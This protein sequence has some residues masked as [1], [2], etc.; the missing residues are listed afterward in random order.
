MKK[1]EVKVGRLYYA[2]VNNRHTVV[3]VDSIR[4]NDIGGTYYGVTNLTTGRTTVF[5][6]AAALHHEVKQEVCPQ[7]KTHV[8]V[9]HDFPFGMHEE[10]Y[11]RSNAAKL[12]KSM[13]KV[14]PSIGNV[15]DN[16]ADEDTTPPSQAVPLVFA[17]KDADIGEGEHSADSI[18]SKFV[19]VVDTAGQTTV[20]APTSLAAKIAAQSAKPRVPAMVAGYT[21]TDEQR[22]ILE[23]V[24]DILNS[25]GPKVLVVN[26]GAGSGKTS[27]LKML[28]DV[29]YG[30]IQYTAYNRPLVDESRS[31]F[32]KAKC[33][34]GH[35]L[36]FAPV[37]KDYKHRL[38]GE[39]IRS[40]DVARMLG[41]EPYIIE[42]PNLSIV[43]DSPEWVEA[44]QNAGYGEGLSR[45]VVPPTDWVPK[46]LK[47]VEAWLLAGHVS[48]ALKRFS[49]T[50]DQE[51]GM[52]HFAYIDGIDQVDPE[53]G[54]RS[55]KN[56]DRVVEYLLPF[57]KKFWA[58]VCDVN[59]VL[60]YQH[61]FYVKQWQ[62]SST[63]I[64]PADHILLDE[65]FPVG[66]MVETDRGPIPIETISQNP[67]QWCVLSSLNGGRTTRYTKVTSAY[68]TPRNG[69]LVRIEHDRGE[70]VCTANHPIW[71]GGRGW[72]AAGLVERGDTL[73][74]LRKANEE[75]TG[76]LLSVLCK[77]ATLSEGV[78]RRGSSQAVQDQQENEGSAYRDTQS[79]G[80]SRC[81]REGVGQNE[82]T[83]GRTAGASGRQWAGTDASRIAVVQGT[84]ASPSELAVEPR[85]C[86]LQWTTKERV[87]NLLQDRHSISDETHCGR[88]GRRL[89]QEPEGQRERC[90]EDDRIRVSRVVSVEVYQPGDREQPGTSSCGDYRSVY[91][92]SVEAGNYYADGV[93]A[94]NCQDTAPVFADVIRRQ[95]ATIIL[96]GDENQKIYEWR[97]ACN[98]T[99]LFPDAPILYLSQSF[100]FGQAVADI[101]NSVLTHLTEPT[102]LK[103]RG[104]T[105]IP[106]RVL[107]DLPTDEFGNSATDDRESEHVGNVCY[108]YRT[109]AGA[110]G[111][112][113]TEFARGRRGCLVGKV[114]EV[115]RWVEAARDLQAAIPKRTSHPELAVFESWKEVQKYVEEDP[116]GGDLKLMVKLVDEFTCKSILQALNNMPEEKDADFVCSTSHKSKGRE[117]DTVVLGADFPAA[118]K[119]Q[120]SDVRLLY[121]AA[122]R[123]KLVLDLT[124]CTP[125]HSYRDKDGNEYPAIEINYTTDMPSVNELV[126]YRLVKDAPHIAA[127]TVSPKIAS[128][129]SQSANGLSPQLAPVNAAQ[130]NVATANG[131]EQSRPP[132]TGFSWTNFGGKWLVRGP[133]GAKL[134]DRVKVVKKSGASSDE[135]LKSVVREFDDACIYSV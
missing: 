68:C 93:L 44:A 124:T 130:A 92:L 99:D 122:T 91:T 2:R 55:R 101:A 35:G 53:T 45:G 34:T 88:S 31:K 52:K 73:S 84:S 132:A 70:L 14:Q 20:V 76:V 32:R 111:R 67:G 69:P 118:H 87:P 8:P 64:I 103:M 41:I 89:A 133:L 74:Y 115:V 37:G 72:V 86:R 5:R 39:R 1:H 25:N 18:S 135:V 117:W 90:Q 113:L 21:P 11:N 59:G 54:R 61:D 83:R 30:Q 125:F 120:D 104:L 48:Q 36:A 97:G 134:G 6:S 38:N 10:C 106:S 129:P 109:N 107:L 49:Q 98:A 29:L 23:T 56:N 51:I 19:P 13:A 28:E 42:V 66:T 12:D 110:L 114:D 105:T 94:K 112:I 7:C 24:L 17:E 119:M 80:S 46:S 79:N 26:A 108:L 96:V 50:T 81:Q 126:A 63:A 121:V 95:R 116:D 27:T 128:T 4:P 78:L 43:K 3:R 57:A 22:A 16:T 47:T 75:E 127:P 40:K 100:R 77:D 9:G 62:L 15:T 60:P 102:K 82:G 123:A 71:V 65:C 85:V 131:N 33:S 58:D